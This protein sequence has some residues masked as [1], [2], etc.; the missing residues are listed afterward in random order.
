MRKYYSVHT[1]ITEENQNKFPSSEIGE[2]REYTTT[3]QL[4]LAINEL[5][6]LAIEHP[7]SP[8]HLDRWECISPTLDEYEIDE[9]FRPISVNVL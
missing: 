2:T 5:Q 1:T 3:N 9:G 8:A 6:H 7:N 4:L